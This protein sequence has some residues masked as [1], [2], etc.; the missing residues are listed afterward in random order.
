[1]EILPEWPCRGGEENRTEGAEPSKL[2]RQKWGLGVL[3]LGV[4]P[5]RAF[6]PWT[7]ECDLSWENRLSRCSPGKDFERGLNPVR[8][9]PE[10]DRK[11]EDSRVTQER[12]PRGDRNKGLSMASTGQGALVAGGRW[13]TRERLLLQPQEGRG[14]ADASTG[15][16]GLQNGERIQ[17]CCFK[18]LGLWQFLQ[19]SKQRL[20][21]PF[22]LP[23]RPFR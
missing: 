14:P 5:Q 9:V 2:I 19:P 12:R 21:Q 15:T 11:E 16:S 8:R 1:M 10:S 22:L 17:F 23:R 3:S 20:W 6:A 4:A 7:S 18:T 13:K